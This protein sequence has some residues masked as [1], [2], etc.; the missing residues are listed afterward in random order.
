MVRQLRQ[1]PVEQPVSPGALEGGLGIV[2]GG[3]QS[4]P[5]R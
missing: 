4:V 3:D 1:R 5:V 2:P